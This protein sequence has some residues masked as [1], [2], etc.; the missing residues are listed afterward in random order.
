M[1]FIFT[2]HE[3]DLV[4][5]PCLSLSTYRTTA[6]VHNHFLHEYHHRFTC[7]NV[8]MAFRLT[9]VTDDPNDRSN[10]I[11]GGGQVKRSQYREQI[12]YD[13]QGLATG[14]VVPDW[15]SS[16]GRDFPNPL[17]LAQGPSPPPI[18]L[19]PSYFRGIP[20]GAWRYLVPYVTPR[21]IQE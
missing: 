16:W 3:W 15:N 21:L 4:C 5:S 13:V 8:S 12:I 10:I 2:K 17:K 7:S 18:Q 14:W 9:I 1:K 20:A 11:F 6:K 19:V